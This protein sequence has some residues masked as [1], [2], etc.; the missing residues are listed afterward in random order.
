MLS[1]I[2]WAEF[3]SIT[4]ILLSLYYTAIL[5]LFYRKEISNLLRLKQPQQKQEAIDDEDDQ[6]REDEGSLGFEGLEPVVADIR[7]IFEKAGKGASKQL[8]LQLLQQRLAGYAGLRLP[9]FRNAIN[10]FIITNAKDFCGVGFSET[11]LD[12][13]WKALPR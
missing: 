8:L 1:K 11:E 12:R 10:Q 2:S 4:V 9:A 7:G 13:E 3:L 5:I 6:G